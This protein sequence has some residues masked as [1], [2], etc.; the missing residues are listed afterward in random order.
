MKLICSIAAAVLFTA[1]TVLAVNARKSEAPAQAAQTALPETKFAIVD[2]EEFGDPKTGVTR[3]VAAFA[4]IERDMKPKRDELTALQTRY[5]QLVK[6]IN[7]T[8]KVADQKTLAD[9]ADQAELLQKDI[10]R[11]QEDGQ[12]DMDKRMKDL[13]DPIYLELTNELQAFARQKG[14]SVII[15]IS[16]FRGSMVVLN[17]Q[18][19][20]TQ[21]FI[22]NYNSKP[23]PAT[24]P[25]P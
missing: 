10:K 1:L 24:A 20:L 2:T 14:A 17:N 22:A 11:K 15:D 7:E 6:E 3:L 9:K 8:S 19:D 12:R 18:I 23:A 5:E 25:K 16:K 21:A 4:T 13:T